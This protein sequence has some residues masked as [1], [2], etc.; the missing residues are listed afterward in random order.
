MSGKSLA[1]KGATDPVT[2]FRSSIMGSFPNLQAKIFGR[3]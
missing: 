3:S 1:Q 2:V